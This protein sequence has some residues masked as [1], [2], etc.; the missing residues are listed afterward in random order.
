MGK[1]KI[2]SGLLERARRAAEA[3]GYSSVEEFV[4]H[5]VEKELARHEA[6]EAERNVADQLRGLGYI[7]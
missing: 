7:E 2:D 5:L 6:D 1:I 3:A 4:T